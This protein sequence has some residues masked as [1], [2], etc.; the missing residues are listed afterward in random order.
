MESTHKFSMESTH[1]QGKCKFSIVTRKL[2]IHPAC[3]LCF[4]RV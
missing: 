1:P 4:V 2:E 3:S